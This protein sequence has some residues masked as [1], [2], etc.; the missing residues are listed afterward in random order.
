MEQ[1]ISTPTGEIVLRRAT[2]SNVEIVRSIM[3][4]AGEIPRRK[5]LDMW[6]WVRGEIGI[7]VIG[8]RIE[9]H[10]VYIGAL[11]GRDVATI[12]IQWADDTW[13]QRGHDEKAGYIHGM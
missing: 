3:G 2:I 12:C 13:D 4:S 8:R 9:E 7:K 5:G 10:E 1:R 11:G 6:S